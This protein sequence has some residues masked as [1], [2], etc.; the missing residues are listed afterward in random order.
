[1]IEAPSRLP[2]FVEAIAAAATDVVA[3]GGLVLIGPRGDQELPPEVVAVLFSPDGDGATVD[4]ERAEGLG[5]RYV[6]VYQVHCLAST[7]TGDHYDE[8][9]PAPVRRARDI[10]AGIEAALK[11]TPGLGVVDDAGLGPSSSWRV[12]ATGDGTAV[13][14]RFSV[15]GR[16]AL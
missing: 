8:V 4:T 3:I 2:E 7:W 6:D 13:D 12:Y 10:L 15:V 14:L 16:A 1:M 11:A 5:H 9:V